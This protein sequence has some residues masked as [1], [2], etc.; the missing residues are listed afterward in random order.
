MSLILPANF[1]KDIRSR[2]TNLF[3]IICIGDYPWNSGIPDFALSTN[4]VTGD[5]AQYNFLPLL[6]NVPSIRESIDIE[7][8]KY[9]IPN[10]TIEISNVPYQGIRLSEKLSD[11]ITNRECRIFWVSPSSTQLALAD[12]DPTFVQDDSAFQVFIGYIREYKHDDEKIKL[13]LEDQSSTKFQKKVPVNSLPAT[14]EIL[15]KYKNKPI[16]MVY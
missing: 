15:D 10:V 13:V 7:K 4:V 9:K 14:P 2:Q 11:E 1:N 16:P 12:I 8:R 6:L 5:L 3:P